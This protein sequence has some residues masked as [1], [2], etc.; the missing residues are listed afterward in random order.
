MA[1]LLNNL[2]KQTFYNLTMKTLLPLL[3]SLFLT[4]SFAQK[5]EI[6]KAIKLFDSGDVQGATAMLESSAALF[7][8]A[9]QKILNQ[10]T[11]L[12]GQ[13]AQSNKDFNLAYEKFMAFKDTGGANPNFD[14]QLNSLTS[15]IVN[16]AIGDNEEKR[17]AVAA[18]KLHLAYQINPEGNQDYLYY[19][20][21]SAVNGSNFELALEYYDELK[22]I[23]YTGITTQYFAISAD[24]GEEVELSASEYDLYKKT[25]QYTDFR[26]EDTESRFPEIVKNIALIYA[27]LGDNERAMDAV[28]EARKEDPKDLNL[29]LTEA[30]LYIQLEENDR[31][32][33][34]MK[35]AIEQ[36]PTN[37]TLYFNLGVIN[38]QR[39]M[40]EEAKG[41][42][43]KSIELDPNSE[44]GYLNL[45]SLILE[46][47][48]TIVEEMNS[49][50]NSRADNARYEQLKTDRENLYLECVPILKKLVALSNNQEA[51][52]TL[53]NIYGTL[54]DNEGFKE[55]KALVE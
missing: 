37:A 33:A 42:Y 38:A 18:G 39:G 26:E 7:D 23:K 15:D 44:S 13:I 46:G 17:F 50:G 11:Y 5:K 22:K 16:E 8:A 29:I 14:T 19:A 20:A 6:K 54:G 30:N 21:S 45:V 35:E 10:K 12:Q 43:Q 52:K 55:M 36:D 49:L 47:E 31:F 51:I 48:S 28:K 2:I 24:S 3:F 9:D 25:K 34:L 1:L 40:N 53:M 41:Y 27:Q 32:E 4:F